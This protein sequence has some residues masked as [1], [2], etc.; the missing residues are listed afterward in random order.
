VKNYSLGVPRTVPEIAIIEPLPAYLYQERDRILEDFARI[1]E[2]KK[3]DQGNIS[4][5][6]IVQ[7]LAEM[8]VGGRL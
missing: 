3:V 8:R 7:M 1:S 6:A 2:V 4:S 5:G